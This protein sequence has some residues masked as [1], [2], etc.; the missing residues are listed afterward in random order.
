[1]SLVKTWYAPQDAADKFGIPIATLLKWVDAG[2]VR[3][4]QEQDVVSR[5]NI[6]D[7]RLEVEAMVREN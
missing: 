5:V 4:E 6:D 2:L 1:M 7:V 3:F